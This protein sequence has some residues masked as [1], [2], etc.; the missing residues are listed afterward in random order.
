MSSQKSTQAANVTTATDELK[1]FA[2]YLEF[3]TRDLRE[4]AAT[5]LLGPNTPSPANAFRREAEDGLDEGLFEDDVDI[6]GGDWVEVT[7]H[8]T[9]TKEVC[10]PTPPAPESFQEPSH[11][12]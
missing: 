4:F 2:R 6:P 5:F 12:Q 10:L 1:R 3:N 8:A 9:E 11:L 7:D